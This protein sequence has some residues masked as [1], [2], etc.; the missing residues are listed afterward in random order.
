MYLFDKSKRL[1]SLTLQSDPLSVFVALM[2]ESANTS[3]TMLLFYRTTQRNIAEGSHLHTDITFLCCS[4]AVVDHTEHLQS[5]PNL[6]FY[7]IRI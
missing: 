7:L 4:I 5:L 2:V 1:L 6:C 3:E